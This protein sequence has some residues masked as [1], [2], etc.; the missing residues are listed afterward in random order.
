MDVRWRNILAAPTPQHSLVCPYH[1]H[2]HQWRLI[3]FERSRQSNFTLHHIE[4]A[5]RSWLRTLLSGLT[6]G[7]VV[8]PWD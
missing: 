6:E 1:G 5:H 4:A 8:E 7:Y 2:K 3:D